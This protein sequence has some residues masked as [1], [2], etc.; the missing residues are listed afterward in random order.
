MGVSTCDD[1][2]FSVYKRDWSARLQNIKLI[3]DMNTVIGQSVLA[4]LDEAYGYLRLDLAEIEAAKDK[5]EA[6]IR[7]NE[8][9]KAMGK[10]EEKRNRFSREFSN[11][12]RTDANHRHVRDE[13]VDESSLHHY[14]S[15]C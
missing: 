7:Q 11:R 8:R 15:V 13:S 9:S 1:E 5:T 6:I 2:T 14:Q 4:Q 3:D 12:G 10:N